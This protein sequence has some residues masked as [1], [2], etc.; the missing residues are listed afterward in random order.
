MNEERRQGIPRWR[1]LFSI[2]TFEIFSIF[3][4]KKNEVKFVLLKFARTIIPLWL[5]S[6][7]GLRLIHLPVALFCFFWITIPSAVL[8][9]L[10]TSSIIPISTIAR[11][12]GRRSALIREFLIHAAA[13]FDLAMRMYDTVMNAKISDL[14]SSLLQTIYEI[15]SAWTSPPSTRGKAIERKKFARFNLM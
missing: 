12:F 1:K 9:Y 6:S 3:K 13:L 14:I 10:W 5:I 4:T 8:L 2:S 15:F 11:K 7:P